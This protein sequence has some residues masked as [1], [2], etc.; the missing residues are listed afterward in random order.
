MT[1][2]RCLLEHPSQPPLIADQITTDVLTL[3]RSTV[4]AHA[5]GG[6]S[7]EGAHLGQFKAD[8]VTLAN[9]GGP[10]VYADGLIVDQDV[11][12]ADGASVTGEGDSG[13]FHVIGARIGG[14]LNC[15][16][17]TFSSKS[18]PALVA[19]NLDAS[20][21]VSLSG[22]F[23]A[24]GDGP[25]GVVRLAVTHI[26][27][28]LNCRDATLAST[29]GRALHAQSL[30]VDQDVLLDGSF[31]ATGGRQTPA[32]YLVGMK[33][34]GKLVLDPGH[35][36]HTAGR[37][38]RLDVDGL[39]YRGLPEQVTPERWLAMIQEDTALHQPTRRYRRR[40]RRRPLTS[41]ALPLARSFG[42]P[43]PL[44]F[45]PAAAATVAAGR[46]TPGRLAVGR[47]APCRSTSMSSM[48]SARAI[49]PAARYG[50]FRC[51]FT[52]HRRRTSARGELPAAM[53]MPVY[54][55]TA[56]RPAGP[57]R[58]TRPG[59]RGESPQAERSATG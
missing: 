18:G 53:P 24:S 58:S 47:L 13:A 55:P 34:G 6:V 23:N 48:L 8:G 49:I 30:Q 5:K 7:L 37:R 42:I 50:T 20:G 51:A 36:T 38:L 1:L 44:T 54:R 56:A 17:A 35:V 22:T 16:N 9:D 29:S 32:L 59:R 10:A 3:D 40:L 41:F 15:T 33:V 4:R 2:E 46:F 52:P 39:T 12:F 25:K 21:D 45:A 14:Q 57:P 31:N 19:D 27:G 43:G 28:Q 11:S 26:G